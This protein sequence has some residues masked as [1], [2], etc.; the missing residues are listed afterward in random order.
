MRYIVAETG[1]PNAFAARLGVT[2]VTAAS[3][4]GELSDEEV[5]LL[6]TLTGK[7]L[8]V[9]YSMCKR[10]VNLTAFMQSNVNPFRKIKP[11]Y[12]EFAFDFVLLS[13]RFTREEIHAFMQREKPIWTD[14]TIRSHV[15]TAL[16]IFEVFGCIRQESKDRFVRNSY[17]A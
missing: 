4:K 16:R 2:T 3:R 7:A 8:Q 15:S 9:A 14:A 17:A 13:E 5:L 6:S 1:K 11:R 10:G 12:M